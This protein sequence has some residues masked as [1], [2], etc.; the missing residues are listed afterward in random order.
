MPPTPRSASHRSL[1]RLPCAAI[2]AALLAAAIGAPAAGPGPAGDPLRGKQLA[3]VCF[4][5]HGLDGNSPSPVDPKI[6]GQHEQYLFMALMA[7]RSGGRADSLM[8]GAVLDKSEQDLRDIAAYYARQP[9]DLAGSGARAGAAG[10]PAPPAG[11]S[12][13][14]R[15]DH[16]ERTA[17]FTSLVARADA[18]A[19]AFTPADGQLCDGFRDT[20]ADADGDEVADRYDAAP[21]DEAEFAADRNGDGRLEICN[22]QQLQAIAAAATRP[23][24]AYQLVR[25]LDAAQLPAFRPVG[26]CGPTGNCM[27]ALGKYGFA[28]VFDGQGHVIRNLEIALPTGSGVG[29]FG[30]LAESGVVMNVNLADVRISGRAGVGALVGSN[31][32]VLF[33]SRASG[34]VSG[35]LA[36]GGLVGGSGGLVY[37]SRFSG[38]VSGQQAVGGLVGDMTGAVYYSQTDVAVSGQRGIGGLVGLN[39]FGS[40]LGSAAGGSV[41]GSNDI[42]GLVGVNTDARIR[43]SFATA[44]VT[45]DGNN[46]GGLVGFNS[47]ST[48]R[49]SYATGP[50]S[51]ADGVGGL[52][53]RNNGV[54]NNSYAAGPVRGDGLAGGIVGIVVEGRQSGTYTSTINL[55]PYGGVATDLRTLSGDATGWAPSRLPAVDWLDLFCDQNRNGFI[56][57]VEARPENYIWVFRPERYPMLRCAAVTPTL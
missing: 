52:V 12:G 1:K 28:G 50:V 32:G 56:D 26:D 14:T 43:Q 38:T 33:N 22:V 13:V 48:V 44:E 54:V 21:D 51:G 46:A 45:C 15:F 39:T 34:T 42:G 41:A 10:S 9:G 5:C 53:G 17:A 27:R 4:A 29:L 36:V 6:G 2:V 31:F 57:P 19:A 11:A 55:T 3:A 16:G 24:R 47:L 35:A 23:D 25:D 49:N 37:R 40:V 18:L 7:Y 8:A 30:V 20:A